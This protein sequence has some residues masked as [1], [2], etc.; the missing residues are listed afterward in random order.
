MRGSNLSAS[1]GCGAH[2]AAACPLCAE[3]SHQRMIQSERFLT[4]FFARLLNSQMMQDYYTGLGAAHL[5]LIYVDMLVLEPGDAGVRSQDEIEEEELARAMALQ[6]KIV[7][8]N[9][10]PTPSLGAMILG[11]RGDLFERGI[12]VCGV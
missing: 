4:R 2:T 5:R 12:C 10:Q 7:S 9:H 3:R 6:P 11:T 1:L 8:Q